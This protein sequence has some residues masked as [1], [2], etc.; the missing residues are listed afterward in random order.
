MKYWTEKTDVT[1][2]NVED[3]N[4]LIQVLAN[5]TNDKPIKLPIIAIRRTD[6]FTIKNTSKRP[7]SFDGK[8]IKS[9]NNIAY[10]YLISKYYNNEITQEEYLKKCEELKEY[11]ISE[12]ISF[13]NA[14]P[15]RIKYTLDVYTRYQKENDLYIRNLIFNIINYPKMRVYFNYNGIDIEHDTNIILGDSVN[16]ESPSIKLFPDQICK[17]SLFLTIDDAYLWDTRVKGSVSLSSEGLFLQIKDV[18]GFITEQ[19]N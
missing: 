15:I 9:E 3:S 14:I 5:K 11:S 6:G 18:D 13:L 8:K 4:R 19:I 12:P 10:D 16:F 7:L 1:V 2:Y 17:Q